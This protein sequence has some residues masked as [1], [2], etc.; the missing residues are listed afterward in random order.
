MRGKLFIFVL[1]SIDYKIAVYLPAIAGTPLKPES[2]TT[3]SKGQA[4]YLP[5]IA[6]TPLKLYFNNMMADQI[7]SFISR[8]SPGLH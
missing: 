7:H 2:R 5:A 1:N 8:Q 6:G 3:T 4:V